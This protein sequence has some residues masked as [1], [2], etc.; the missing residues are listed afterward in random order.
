MQPI[1]GVNVVYQKLKSE[2]ISIANR[3]NDVFLNR[4]IEKSPT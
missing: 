2:I 4:Y 3:F 1:I